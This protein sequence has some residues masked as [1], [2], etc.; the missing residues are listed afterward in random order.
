ML[1]L[2]FF[3]RII[4]C[5][6][7]GKLSPLPFHEFVLREVKKQ[8]RETGEARITVSD[9]VLLYQKYHK[10]IQEPTREIIS[11]TMGHVC[12]KMKRKRGCEAVYVPSAMYS[13]ILYRFV[14]T[15]KRGKANG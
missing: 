14:N 4:H 1:N 7:K 3:T 2:D 13:G 8:Y 5:T 11:F 10:Q 15:K 6:E 12:G 9:I